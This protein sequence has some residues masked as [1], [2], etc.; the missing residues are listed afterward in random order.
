MSLYIRVQNGF[1]THRKTMCLRVAL[2]NDA[3]WIPPRLWAYA[4][5]NQPDGCFAKYPPE[6]IAMSIGY[7]GDASS[8]LQALLEAGFMD[9]NPLRIHDWE[10]YNG[11]HKSFAE[12][13]AL[14]GKAKAEKE[15]LRREVGS[16]PLH[17][18]DRKGKDMRGD[19]TSTASSMPEAERKQILGDLFKRRASTEWDVKELKA[20]KAKV[21]PAHDDDFALIAE[22]YRSDF[23]YKR[24]D[25]Q[26]LLN[27]WNG[28][29]DR[30]RDW[31]RNPTTLFQP[32]KQ[33]Q[34]PYEPKEL[35]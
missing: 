25:L 8:M 14:G 7:L 17:P 22:Y 10:Q 26:T 29:V 28:E 31:K 33:N 6:Q 1:F 30:A 16:P 24:K 27:N 9:A 34:Q 18:P 32:Q 21:I 19:E 35:N 23:P 15:R 3:L 20:F 2:G 11:F 12:R 4:A 5:E 13:A